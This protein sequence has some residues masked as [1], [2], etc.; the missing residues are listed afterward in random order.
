MHMP[1]NAN[2][3]LELLQEEKNRNEQEM[4]EAR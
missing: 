4:T 2:P 3:S 1:L